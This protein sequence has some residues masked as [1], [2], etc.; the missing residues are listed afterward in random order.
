[1]LFIFKTERE[2]NSHL[3][4]SY[5]LQEKGVFKLHIAYLRAQATTISGWHEPQPCLS[6]CG[7]ILIVYALHLIYKEGPNDLGRVRKAMTQP[8]DL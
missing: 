4:F 2:L 1:M 7:M 6:L 8:G 5:I 3:V